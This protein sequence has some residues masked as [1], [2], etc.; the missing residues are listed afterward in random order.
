MIN[1]KHALKVP[2]IYIMTALGKASNEILSLLFRA[3][4]YQQGEQ[5]GKEEKGTVG[6]Y[7]WD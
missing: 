6:L 5:D 1:I 4:S 3:L 7:F 2:F